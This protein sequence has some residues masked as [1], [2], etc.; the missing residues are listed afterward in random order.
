MNPYASKPKQQLQMAAAQYPAG[1]QYQANAQYAQHPQ[2]AQHPQQQQHA[3]HP[4]HTQHSQ[5]TQHPQHSQ[6][7]Q[8]P[9]HPHMQMPMQYQHPEFAQGFDPQHPHSHPGQM[10]MPMGAGQRPERPFKEKHHAFLKAIWNVDRL[11]PNPAD[12]L[13]E[14]HHLIVEKKMNPAIQCDILHEITGKPIA[15]VSPLHIACFE[16]DADVIRYL[17]DNGADPNQTESEHHLTPIHVLCDS[18]Y[19]GQSLRVSKYIK[20]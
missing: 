8:H 2:H 14:L 5:H 17:I 13:K 12:K 20:I 19:A 16:G 7:S 10:P 11:N 3:Q 4:Q 1:G 9:Q 6:H 15:Q 18:E